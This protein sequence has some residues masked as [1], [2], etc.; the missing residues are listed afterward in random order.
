MYHFWTSLDLC[1]L[2]CEFCLCMADVLKFGRADINFGSFF[3]TEWSSRFCLDLRVV[4][5]SPARPILHEAASYGRV[6]IEST[7]ALLITSTILKYY[8]SYI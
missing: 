1:A 8:V 5:V 7:S 3:N 6:H 4:F 2:G